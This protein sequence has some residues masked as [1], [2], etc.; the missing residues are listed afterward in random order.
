[1]SAFQKKRMLAKP[2]FSGIVSATRQDKTTRIRL[3]LAFLLLSG[4]PEKNQSKSGFVQK[5][6]LLA[7]PG[8]SGI[9]SATRQDKTT[10]LRL[11]LAFLLLSGLP[12][13]NSQS[14]GLPPKTS[15]LALILHSADLGSLSLSA[16]VGLILLTGGLRHGAPRGAPPDCLAMGTSSPGS[17]G[18]ASTHRRKAVSRC[19]WCPAPGRTMPHDELT[20]S[21]YE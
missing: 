15:L 14:L 4:L 2:G 11:N 5:K 17:Y 19:Q 6:Q 16:I 1:M 9:V 12:E 18:S 21:E 13:K 8:F 3:N 7:K 10:R 20:V